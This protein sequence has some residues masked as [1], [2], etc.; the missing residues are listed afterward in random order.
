[1]DRTCPTD[2]RI[3]VI[4]TRVS[5]KEQADNNLS[6]ETQEKACLDYA[7]R[8]NIEV[9]RIMGQT[10]ESAKTEGKLYQEMIAYVS[11]HRTINTILVYS[12]DRFSRAGA[13]AIV[14]KAYLKSKGITVISV[15]QPVDS[16]SKAGEFME[17]MIFLFNQFENNLRKEKC[18]AGM[19]ECLERGEWYSKPPVGYQ[20]DRTTK[21]KHRLVIDPKGRLI[22]KAFHWKADEH[23][24]DT[25]IIRRLRLEGWE[26]HKQKLSEIFHNPFY[27]GK[28][29][30]NLLGDRVVDGIHP[31]IIDEHTF[32]VVN[33]IETHS[34]YEHAEETPEV[35]LKMHIICP[36][37]GKHMTG[38]EVKAKHLWYYKCNTKG[39]KCN[40]SAKVMHQKYAEL[41][42]RYQI[43]DEVKDILKEVVESRVR[44][45]LTRANDRLGDLRR[46]KG[47]LQNEKK[48]VMVRF[49]KNLI[50]SDVYEVTRR[51]LDKQIEELDIE[52]K[53]LSDKNSNLEI[54]VAKAIL[55]SCKL[56]DSWKNGN[57]EMR[58]KIQKLVSPDGLNWDRETE[59]Y[60]TLSEN[61]ALRVFRLF[62][63]SYINEDKE[64]TGKSFDFPA[65]V[66][67]AGLEPATSGL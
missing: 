56:G 7:S 41:L 8:N 19:I 60:R 33:G 46:R 54:D 32:N 50:P 16:D 24:S 20:I 30:H 35:P 21:E 17:N 9:V 38:Y 58:Q 37:C 18:T 44:I 59:T 43:P 6:L 52:I 64:K 39:C 57:F 65:V 67:E 49:G 34:G 14:T 1:M 29:R 42:D 63:E 40:K 53:M 47:I 31:A 3:G 66:A 61:E 25:E 62:S 28:I 22:G 36:V 27:C 15:T 23:I 13:E 51:N 4:W 45:Y 10:N 5:T 48:D 11:M 2:R 26:T 12:Y 55:T